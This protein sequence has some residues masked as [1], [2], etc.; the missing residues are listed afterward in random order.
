MRDCSRLAAGELTRFATRCALAI[1][2]PIAAQS[3]EVLMRLPFIVEISGN[4]QWI[5]MVQP[6]D[7]GLARGYNRA[8]QIHP[9]PKFGRI[10]PNESN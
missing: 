9:M 4:L 5:G 7:C 10:S 3:G 1:G 6:I 2:K 8:F